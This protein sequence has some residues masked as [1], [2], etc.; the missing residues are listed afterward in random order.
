MNARLR[1]YGEAALVV[2]TV[3]ALVAAPFI[4]ATLLHRDPAG[5]LL[6]GFLGA[7]AGYALAVGPL[8]LVA[9]RSDLRRAER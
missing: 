7:M 1:L 4:V 8:A 5:L 3:A 9:I 6:V 2:V